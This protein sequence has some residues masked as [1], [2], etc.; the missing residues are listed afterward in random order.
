[1]RL[2]APV[3]TRMSAERD[4]RATASDHVK[5]VKP[6]SDDAANADEKHRCIDIPPLHRDLVKYFIND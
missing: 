6:P 5:P 2:H 1:M 3:G 4:P